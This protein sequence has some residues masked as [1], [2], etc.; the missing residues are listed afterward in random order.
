LVGFIEAMDFV[1]GSYD[2]IYGKV[3][4][5]WRKLNP[6]TYEYKIVIPANCEAQV[7]LPDQ[8]QT[9]KSGAYTFTVYQ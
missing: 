7:I 5:E 3:K 2:S 9:V 4:A 6:N 8:R 1:K